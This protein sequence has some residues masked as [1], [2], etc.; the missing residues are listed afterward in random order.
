Q[1]Y[2]CDAC[3][4]DITNVVRVRCAE[5]PDFDLCVKCFSH[6][7]E[8]REHKR[9][10]AYRVME[11]LNF[12]LYEAHWG[13]D[14]ELLFVE[15]LEMFGLGNWDQISE[16]MG[17]SKTKEEL[18]AHYKN[19]F[20]QSPRWPCPQATGVFDK[21][22]SRLTNRAQHRQPVQFTT[23]PPASQPVNH[24]I[25]GYMPGRGEFEYE[26]ENEAETPIKDMVEC[27]I[28]REPTVRLRTAM[29][30]VYN[31]ALERRK[32]RKKLLFDRHL[33]NYRKIQAAEKRRDRGEKEIHNH[34]KVFARLMTA[35]DHEV[36]VAGLV[37]EAQLLERIEQLQTYRRM[38]VA[39]LKEADEYEQ[40]KEYHLQAMRPHLRELHRNSFRSSRA[41]SPATPGTV[42][43]AATATATALRKLPQPLDI[44]NHEGYDLLTEPEQRVCSRLRLAPR[45][46]LVIKQTMIREYQATG[47]MRRRQARELIKIDVNKTSR[48]Y[49]FFIEMGWIK[50]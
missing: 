26:Y 34:L 41:P 49:D 33:T 16:H 7:Q 3:E 43:T 35:Q 44:S 18:D 42:V 5:C 46:Y 32:E 13:A 22:T 25:A 12:P 19:V 47:S 48:I 27:E 29:L 15:G 21:A 40:H 38:G 11:V 28:I 36:F 39:T 1:K 24:E 6:G 50:R 23:R 2:H 8:L 10:H 9:D 37:K 4:K 45:A 31:T 14:E 20:I 17:G 30:S